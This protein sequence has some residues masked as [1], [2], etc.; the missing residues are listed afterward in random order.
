V[1]TRTAPARFEPAPPCTSLDGV[2]VPEYLQPFAARFATFGRAG[3][4]P[5]FLLQQRVVHEVPEYGDGRAGVSR[6]G[7]HVVWVAKRGELAGSIVYGD[8]VTRRSERWPAPT[9]LDPSH[10]TDIV[11]VDAPR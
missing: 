2:P 7:R 4:A 5:A 8:L 10:V 6:N 1:T 3:L 11:W 9:G